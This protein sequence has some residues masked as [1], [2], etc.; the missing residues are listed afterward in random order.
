MVSPT[1]GRVAKQPPLAPRVIVRQATPS[2]A[3]MPTP[4]PATG[5][6]VQRW[7]G[8]VSPPAAGLMPAQP[9]AAGGTPSITSVSSPAADFPPPLGPSHGSGDTVRLDGAYAPSAAAMDRIVEA[10]EE[11]VLAEIER[12][13]GRYSGI[14]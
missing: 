14:F 2:L 7:I 8:K 9:G 3:P 12:R 4:E 10:I 13:G 11:R 5:G 6:L 1:P